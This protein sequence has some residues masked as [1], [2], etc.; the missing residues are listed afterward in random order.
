[1]AA[2]Y[3]SL[4]RLFLLML[5]RAGT[6][7]TALTGWAAPS[8]A[9]RPF[10]GTDAAV[11]D[12]G[13][14]EIELQ[15][16]GRLRDGSDTTLIAPWWVYNYGFAENWEAVLEG[17]LET[18]LS[19]SDPT[20]LTTAGAF[21]KHVLRPGSL[22]DQEGPSI[23]T[24]FGALLPG[25]NA[26]QGVGASFAVIASQRWEWGTVHLNLQTELT[27]DHNADAFVS[28]IVEGPFKWK[29]RPV[30]EFFYEEEFGQARTASAL[31]GMIWQVNDKLALDMA[32]RQAVT[33][34]RPVNELR[35][36]LTVG[37]PLWQA[38][39]AARKK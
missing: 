33:N 5:A 9:Y 2:T 38:E 30:A 39:S 3:R 29:V 35:A 12:R 18:P 8:F 24:E 10:D 26:E 37:F 17:R 36:G 19:S 16:A 34:G 21:L 25:V 31:V 32:V 22:Q 1:M 14:F 7:F 27:R 4:A 15:P 11:A 13:E 28:A 6:L 23:A 20:S